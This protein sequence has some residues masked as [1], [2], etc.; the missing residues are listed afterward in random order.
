[1]AF[2]PLEE[3]KAVGVDPTDPAKTA[4]IGTQLPAK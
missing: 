1:M 4:W 3:T 2:H